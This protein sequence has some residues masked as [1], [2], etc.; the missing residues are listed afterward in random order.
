MM[1]KLLTSVKAKFSFWAFLQLP[2]RGI[3]EVKFKRPVVI[4]VQVTMSC[5]IVLV[6]PYK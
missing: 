2:F 6:F 3:L 1:K 4:L 5:R